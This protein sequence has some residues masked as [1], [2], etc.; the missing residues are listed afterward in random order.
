[1]F[2]EKLLERTMLLQGMRISNHEMQRRMCDKLQVEKVTATKLPEKRS[3]NSN[4]KFINCL[5]TSRY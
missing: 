4:R 3:R 5:A 1:M 2:P